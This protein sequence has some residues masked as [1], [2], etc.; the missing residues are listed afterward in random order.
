[1][2]NPNQLIRSWALQ[3]S[4][5]NGPVSE[6]KLVPK[7]FTRIRTPFVNT[8]REEQLSSTLQFGSRVKQVR[9]P[10]LRNQVSGSASQR[11]LD[12]GSTSGA[13]S[14]V[15]GPASSSTSVSQRWR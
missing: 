3:G 6:D 9:N 7:E 10:F 5:A 15:G 2:E 11:Q 13:S 4:F 8:W 1:M 12:L 14:Q